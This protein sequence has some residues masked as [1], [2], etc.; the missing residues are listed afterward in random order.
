MVRLLTENTELG[1]AYRVDLRLR[2]EGQRGPM[3]MSLPAMLTYYDVRG[4][5]WERQAY[6]KARPVAG[7][8]DLGRRVPG[9]DW[10]PGSTA[11]T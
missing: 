11:A 1:C 3:V 9:A 7:D 10:R 8:L 6:I 5:T 2:P 4:R